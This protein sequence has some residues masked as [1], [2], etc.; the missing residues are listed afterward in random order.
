MSPVRYKL[1]F[2]IPQDDILHSHCREKLKSR[3]QH[4][5]D[6][7]IYKTAWRHIPEDCTIDIRSWIHELSS[8]YRPSCSAIQCLDVTWLLLSA[9]TIPSSTGRH[10]TRPGSWNASPQLRNA[11]LRAILRTASGPKRNL[12]C[13]YAA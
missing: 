2:Y 5:P 13:L 6:S 1:G 7:Q 3:N 12:S 10:H 4:D 8:R 9:S 11:R